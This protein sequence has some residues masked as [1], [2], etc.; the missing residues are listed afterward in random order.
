MVAAKTQ[1]LKIA[2]RLGALAL[3]LIAAAALM[4]GPLAAIAE[5]GQPVTEIPKIE[6]SGATAFKSKLQAMSANDGETD[7]NAVTEVWKKLRSEHE[8]GDVDAAAF[9]AA[10][11][12][13]EKQA[14]EQVGDEDK[15]ESKPPRNYAAADSGERSTLD[16]LPDWSSEQLMAFAAA[17][18]EHKKVYDAEFDERANVLRKAARQI[19]AVAADLDAAD[20]DE[21]ADVLFER[22]RAL[23]YEA[24][25]V[26]APQLPE[27]SAH[28]DDLQSLRYN[29]HTLRSQFQLYRVEHDG[30]FP[31]ATPDA[32]GRV[33]LHQLTTTTNVKGE[34]GDGPEFP[35]GPYLL[36]IPLNPLTE[37]THAAIVIAIDDWPPRDVQPNAGWLYHPQSGRIAPNSPGHLPD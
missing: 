21:Q 27:A 17:A 10:L 23:R 1:V 28:E 6:L 4:R 26:R 24:R 16:S 11:A 35:H 22:A 36:S 15:H 32:E 8:R 2:R 13:I 3:G 30:R 18:I 12:Q 9:A 25:R 29:L 33:T 19:D 5:E 31:E 34:I 7:L 20:F 37:T 14:S